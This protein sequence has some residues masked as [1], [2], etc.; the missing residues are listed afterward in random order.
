MQA[1]ELC[2]ELL[3]I[4]T[5]IALAYTYLCAARIKSQLIEAKRTIAKLK[6][7]KKDEKSKILPLYNEFRNLVTDKLKE[8]EDNLVKLQ[9]R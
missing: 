1:K 2:P 3:L 9:K 8:Y 7:N 6:E 5:I 4:T